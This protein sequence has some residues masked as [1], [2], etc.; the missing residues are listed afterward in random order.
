MDQLFDLPKLA[1]G[2][3]LR[4][5]PATLTSIRVPI[6]TMS[7]IVVAR[8]HGRMISEELGASDV[9]ITLVGTIISELA[10]NIVLFAENGH[11]DLKQ[12]TTEAHSGITVTAID[13]GPGIDDVQRALLGGYSTCGRL[14]L[15]LS[16]VYRIADE[17]DVV[18]TSSSG[19]TVMARK[20]F[21]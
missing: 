19:T 1:E 7:D 12:I 3:A 20:W 14:G 2:V 18:C 16:G 8:R 15:G 17:F 6:I 13:Q 9:D 21:K 11:I 5:S 10:R 4:R